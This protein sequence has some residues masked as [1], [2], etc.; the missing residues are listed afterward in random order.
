MISS[1]GKPLNKLFSLY[2]KKRMVE[3]ENFMK[4]PLE[5]QD[6]ALK[7]IIYTA[8]NTEFGLSNGFNYLRNSKEFKNR[9]LLSKYDD[10]LPFIERAKN[11]ES[12]ILWPG[13]VKF[14][15]QSSGTTNNVI[16]NIPVTLDSLKECH[17]KGGKDLLSIYYKNNPN[18][19]LF[20]GKHLIVGGNE[21]K[22]SGNTK[23]VEGDLSAIIMKNLPWWCEWRRSPKKIKLLLSQNWEEKLKYVVKNS[24]KDDVQIIAGAPSWVLVIMNEII[25]EKKCSNIHEIWPNLELY[26]HGGMNIQPYKKSFESIIEKEIH[27][28][29][30]YNATEGFFGLQFENNSDDMLLM[31]DYGIYY[32]FIS[33]SHWEDSQPIT[34]G[35]E[36]VKLNTPY[37][38]VISTNGGLW[39]YRLEDTIIFTSILPFKIKVIGRTQQFINMAGEE[40]MIQHVEKAIKEAAEKCSCIVGEFTLAPFLK[41]TNKSVGFHYWVIEF[42]TKPN[43]L[44]RFSK[45]LDNELQKT[46]IDY[47]AKRINNSPLQAPVIKV[48]QKNT[49]Y[50]W[51]KSKNKLGGQNK[52]PRLS[53]T[54]QYINEILEMDIN[55]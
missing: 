25:K 27:F 3:I 2:L 53:T 29:Q 14:F 5:V 31:L 44:I 16:K 33:K 32:E 42:V 19:Q 46:N 47:K 17:Y 18:T 40:L 52:I 39:R 9:V 51:L 55:N 6:Q 43:D 8:K 21:N 23:T 7:K 48:V 36:D 13:K 20:K 1:I 10:L 38:L 4:S 41:T 45:V 49:F 28:Y 35:L 30:N 15:A 26:L 22:F 12:N 50:S 34:L 37:E 54:K 24:P 11:G